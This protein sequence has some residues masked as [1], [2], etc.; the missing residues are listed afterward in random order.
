MD[1]MGMM[2]GDGGADFAPLTPAGINF[3]NQT[4]AYDFLQDILDDSYFQ[5]ESNAFARYFWYA[6]ACAIGLATIFNFSQRCLLKYRSVGSI[7]PL[8]VSIEPC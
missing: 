8:T 7:H 6:I 4:Q 2:S 5:V 3:S 1:D